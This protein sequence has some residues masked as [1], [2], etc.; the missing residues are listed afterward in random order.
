MFE[1]LVVNEL[2]AGLVDELL[3]MKLLYNAVDDKVLDEL[4][5]D[6]L[7]AKKLLYDEVV[8]V[9]VDELLD[10]KLL[11]NAVDD[12]VL[13]EPLVN[14]LLA[15]LL[16]ELLDMK[17]LY[18]V[19]DESVD[20]LLS[21]ILVEV[22][23]INDEYTVVEKMYWLYNSQGGADI[24]FHRNPRCFHSCHIVNNNFQIRCQSM[25]PHYRRYRRY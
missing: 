23:A 1:E 8:D 22:E 4:L 6:E 5:G 9:L 12:E 24:Q 18:D 21:N 19:V 13:D 10:M 2:L 14:E 20:K 11:Y 16:D 15:G 7:V 25:T 17:L 3:E